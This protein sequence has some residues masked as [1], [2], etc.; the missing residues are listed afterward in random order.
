MVRTAMPMVKL[1]PDTHAKL[2]S[3]AREE[4]QTMGEMV[5]VLLERYERE[6]FRKGVI[7]DLKKFQADTEA[8]QRYL[9]EFREWDNMPDALGD[10]PPYYEEDEE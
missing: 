3:I 1:K 4:G 8:Y 10:E 7:E 2:Q 6:Q 5:T 9:D